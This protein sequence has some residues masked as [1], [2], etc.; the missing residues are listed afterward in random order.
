MRALRD[1]SRRAARL[2]LLL[3]IF[4]GKVFTTNCP[5]HGCVEFAGLHE[6]LNMVDTEIA[7]FFEVLKGKPG[8]TVGV[9]QL[10]GTFAGR[11]LGLEPRQN[12]TDLVAIDAVAA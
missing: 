5:T 8:R 11:P 10:L 1:R 12:A 2:Q 7:S 9:I 3:L 6:A 4:V